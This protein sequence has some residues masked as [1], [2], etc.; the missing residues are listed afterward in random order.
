MRHGRRAGADDSEGSSVPVDRVRIRRR[1]SI[2]FPGHLPPVSEFIEYVAKNTDG[3][4]RKIVSD[5]LPKGP[6]SYD[7]PVQNDTARTRIEERFALPSTLLVRA[8]EYQTSPRTWRTISRDQRSRVEPRLSD[9][10]YDMYTLNLIATSITFVAFVVAIG[11]ITKG[12]RY[13]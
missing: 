2:D 9:N 5:L 3:S 11:W 1:Y 10:R 13:E 6:H 4:D 12:D 7:R 8:S